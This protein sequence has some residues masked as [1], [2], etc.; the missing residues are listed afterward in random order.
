P[1]NNKPQTSNPKPALYLPSVM[2]E[3]TVA[4]KKIFNFSLLKRVFRYASPYKKK[5]YLSLILTILLAVLAPVRPMLIQLTINLFI[6]A[7]DI[8]WVVWIT[9]IQIVLLLVESGFRFYFSFLTAWLG[10][11][12]VNDLRKQVYKKILGLNLSQFDK[13]PI[14]T[15]TTRSINDIESINDIFA[16]GLIPI[17]ADLLSIISILL[18]MFV[19]DWKLT[20]ICL[21]P[22]PFLI[23]ATY[24]FK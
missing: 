15:L 5:F 11:S 16:D 10:Q 19:T 3:A 13:T 9:I 12:V 7:K 6:S 23:A 8:D 22:F 20:L 18:V 17:I 24:F 2:A 21:T 14:G 4:R 1:F